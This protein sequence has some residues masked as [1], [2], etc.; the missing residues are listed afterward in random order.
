MPRPT[1]SQLVILR[2]MANGWELGYSSSSF[3]GNYYWIQKGGLGRDGEAKNVHFRTAY[4][5]YKNGLI[6]RSSNKPQ[7]PTTHYHLS[8]KAKK[9]LDLEIEK[10]KNIPIDQLTDEQAKIL[11]EYLLEEIIKEELK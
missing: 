1:K 2:L 3:A 4:S 10:L 8:E 7:F 6:E 11:N 5:L 9:I